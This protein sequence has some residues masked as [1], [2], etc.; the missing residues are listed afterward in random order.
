MIRYRCKSC[1]EYFKD[2][3]GAFCP[4]CNGNNV[5]LHIAH[6][7]DRPVMYCLRCYEFLPASDTVCPFCHSNIFVVDR[8]KFDF[9]D[10]HV[11][12]VVREEWK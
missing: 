4:L 2:G 8:E 6:G 5:V 1:N 12:H 10:W 9:D 11:N 7:V 3:A